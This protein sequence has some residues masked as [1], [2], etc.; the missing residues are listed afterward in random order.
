M[1][2]IELTKLHEMTTSQLQVELQ[3][4]LKA[5]TQARLEKVAGRLK[6]VASVERLA[7]NVA[8]VRA[9]IGEKTV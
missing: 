6:D 5:L 8:R 9:I 3:K 2:R 4:D 1:K 7:D